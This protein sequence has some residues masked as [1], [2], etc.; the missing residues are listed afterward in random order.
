MKKKETL[1]KPELELLYATPTLKVYRSARHPAGALL[2]EM[3]G[4]HWIASGVS[5]QEARDLL[6]RIQS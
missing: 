1:T 5:L 6:R 3:T 2:L 4:S